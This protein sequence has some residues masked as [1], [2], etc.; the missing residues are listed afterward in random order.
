VKEDVELLMQFCWV[1][2][3]MGIPQA[4][5]ESM[6]EN[7]VRSCEGKGHTMITAAMEETSGLQLTS[8][9]EIF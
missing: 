2:N 7:I 1:G 8:L 9:G 3:W 6:Y 5:L 4:K